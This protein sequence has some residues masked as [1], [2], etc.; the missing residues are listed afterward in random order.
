MPITTDCGARRVQRY[1]RQ[2]SIDDAEV[3]AAAP[4]DRAHAILTVGEIDCQGRPLASG[5]KLLDPD[6][7]T[8]DRARQTVGSGGWRA[9]TRVRLER[10]LYIARKVAP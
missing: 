7:L 5:D 2:A 8:G 10:D 9:N 4:L 3:C 1:F 6:M